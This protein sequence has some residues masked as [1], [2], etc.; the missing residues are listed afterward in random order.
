MP[1]RTSP[2]LGW[3]VT[4]RLNRRDSGKEGASVRNRSRS[5]LRKLPDARSDV[6]RHFVIIEESVIMRKLHCFTLDDHKVNSFRSIFEQFSPALDLLLTGPA[7][8]GTIGSSERLKR[9]DHLPARCEIRLSHLLPDF[10]RQR[11]I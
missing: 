1:R 3:T 11:I 6:G 5:L 7:L 4:E 9:I 10:N 2:L 8:Y